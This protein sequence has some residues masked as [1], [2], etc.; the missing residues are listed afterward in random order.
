MDPITSR[1]LHGRYRFVAAALVIVAVLILA[2]LVITPLLFVQT[3]KSSSSQCCEQTTSTTSTISTGTNTSFV[4]TQNSTYGVLTSLSVTATP[5]TPLFD[6][7]NGDLYVPSTLFGNQLSVVS[8]TSNA[9]IATVTLGYGEQN[10]AFDPEND[11]I[12]ATV[13]H[14]GT[15]PLGR[16]GPPAMLL[17]VSG[18]TNSVI[19]NVTFPGSHQVFLGPPVFDASNGD[20]YL[21]SP[22]MT[23][24]TEGTLWVVSGT[25]SAVLATLSM[26]LPGSP[27]FDSYNGD[28][29]VPDQ[30]NS[31]VYRISS[32][33]NTIVASIAVPNPSTPALDPESGGPVLPRHQRTL[34]HNVVERDQQGRSRGEHG[35]QPAV[36]ARVRPSE[37]RALRARH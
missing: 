11:D 8:G 29:Y 26:Q 31:T 9:V 32:A 20:V 24:G 28:I 2:S 4:P 10:L 5:G 18:A 3:T 33:N 7:A 34:H 17:V 13:Q 23:G 6:P 1:N 19:S 37:R 27:F 15:L 35:R 14:S 30:V 12:Y 22:N 21:S 36:D 25:T 16:G